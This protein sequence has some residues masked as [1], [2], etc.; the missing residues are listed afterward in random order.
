MAHHSR[1]VGLRM[2]TNSLYHSA[3]PSMRC[4]SQS[5]NQKCIFDSTTL[6]QLVREISLRGA[7]LM[8]RGMSG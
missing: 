1:T 7:A 5:T 4:Q 3:V 2:L 6:T 8:E